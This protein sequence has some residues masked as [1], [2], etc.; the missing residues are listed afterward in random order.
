M[1]DENEIGKNMKSPYAKS[2]P[3]LGKMQWQSR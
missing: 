2:E 1:N 3:S